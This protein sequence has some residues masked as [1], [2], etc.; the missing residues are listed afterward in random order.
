MSETHLYPVNDF[1]QSRSFINED[2]YAAMYRR[3]VDDPDGFWA[4]QADI[5][6]SWSR[7]WDTV[8][9][10]DMRNGRVTWFAGGSLNISYNCIDRHLPTRA[11]QTAT[12]RRA[13]I[14]A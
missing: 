6:L 9:T 14:R 10:Q 8:F 5:F 11:A 1:M 12:Q 13:G 4:E 3:S 7:K 2:Q